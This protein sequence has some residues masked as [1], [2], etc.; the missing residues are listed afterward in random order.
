MNTFYLSF[1]TRVANYERDQQPWL[2]AAVKARLYP[3]FGILKFAERVHFAASSGEAG[4]L[5]SV[6]VASAMRIIDAVYHLQ[7]AIFSK[8]LQKKFGTIC[9]ISIV[10]LFIT[11]ALT[12]VEMLT[13]SM[14]LLIASTSL[15]VSLLATTVS[16]TT[17]VGSLA[18][19]GYSKFA[20]RRHC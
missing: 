14:Q 5:A 20:S 10:I 16:A 15:L 9:K 17:A 12:I 8:R 4:A 3:L 2:Q 11:M 19:R 7:P 6:A 18:S 1:S 13:G